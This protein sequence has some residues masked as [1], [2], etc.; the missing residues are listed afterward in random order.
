[1]SGSGSSNSGSSSSNSESAFFYR[2]SFDELTKSLR[3]TFPE[4]EPGENPG[5]IFHSDYVGRANKRQLVF[6]V[7]HGDADTARMI[8]C[9]TYGLPM[10]N[11]SRTLLSKDKSADATAPVFTEIAV[12]VGKTADTV[13]AEYVSDNNL[14]LWRG[15]IARVRA[16]VADAKKSVRAIYIA[17]IQYWKEMRE[18]V[19]DA[20][21]ASTIHVPFTSSGHLRSSEQR[22]RR[23]SSSVGSNPVRRASSPFTRKAQTMHRPSSSDPGSGSNVRRQRR[24][25][26][27]TARVRTPTPSNSSQR[28]TL[29]YRRPS[30]D[31]E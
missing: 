9:V 24:L 11:A 2:D 7:T 31:P 12:P 15:E 4:G 28:K 30:T 27:R 20:I 29:R 22:R 21:F 5:F 10:N 25:R 23:V 14:A 26:R 19:Q 1:M 6:F 3:T 18:H 17:L 16:L 13:I 8:T